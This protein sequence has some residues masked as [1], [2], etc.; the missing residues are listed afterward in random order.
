MIMS[1]TFSPSVYP[2]PVCLKYLAFHSAASSIY[3]AQ[4]FKI[5]S[6]SHASMS[7]F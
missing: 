5:Y 4:V 6:L 1:L 7:F 3:Q 2:S